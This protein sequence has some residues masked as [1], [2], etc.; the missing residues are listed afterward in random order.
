[1]GKTTY[2]RPLDSGFK[3]YI[4]LGLMSGTSLDGLDICCV[5]FRCS[6]GVWNFKILAS[7]TIPLPEQIILG[8]ESFDQLDKN[9]LQTL[10]HQMGVFTG[11]A[12]LDFLSQNTLPSIHL[13]GSHGHTVFHNPNQGL[14][15]QIGNGPEIR[16]LTGIETICD[17]RVADVDL[18]GQGAPLVPIGDALLFSDIPCC[19]NLGGFANISYDQKGTRWAYDL[20]PVNFVLN[21]WAQKEGIP[22][23]K[24]G[25]LSRTGE[26][27]LP[28]LNHLN[29]L[30]YYRQSPP[31]SLGREWIEGHLS[32]LWETYATFSNA[33]I[34]ATYTEHAAHVISQELNTQSGPVLVTGGGAYNKFLIEKVK[35]KSFVDLIIPQ[36]ELIDF[37]EALIFA[38]LAVLRHRGETNIWSSVT[39]AK[40]DHSSGVIWP[41]K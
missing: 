36:T 5:R 39:G 6:K 40:K 22:Y 26:I 10:S 15:L 14:T 19:L 23:D 25:L 24:D 7:K 13:I 1:M 32:P 8:I 27:I 3:E 16:D 41:A 21:A 18:G 4:V 29:A 31:K 12:I 20:C 38:F 33:D 2:L 11:E 35:Q 9:Q 34:L 17:F 37:K 28:L 30:P